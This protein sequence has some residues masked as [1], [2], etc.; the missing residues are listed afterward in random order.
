MAEIKFG[1]KNNGAAT[2][3]TPSN[4]LIEPGDRLHFDGGLDDKGKKKT[5]IIIPNDNV[6]SV[7]ADIK[8]PMSAIEVKDVTV[9]GKHDF[10]VSFKDPGGNDEDSG[11]H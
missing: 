6:I 3:I 7:H 1:L 11:S 9:S 10:E 8:F 4:I 2:V 5:T